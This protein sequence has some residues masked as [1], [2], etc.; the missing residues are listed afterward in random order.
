MASLKWKLAQKLEYIWWS[1]YLNKKAKGPYLQ[2]K[3]LYWKDL[4]LTISQD[5]PLPSNQAI[6]DAGCG[7]AGIFMVLDG[8]RVEAIDPLLDQ[9]RNLEH[10]QPKAYSWTTFYSAPIESLDAE[11]KYDI[12]FCINAINHVNDIELCCKNLVRA[13]KPDGKLILSTDAH[14]HKWLKKLF[15]ILPGDL[16]HPVQ[17]DIIEYE[18]L[19]TRQDLAIQKRVL[20]K[21]ENIFNYYILIANKPP[22]QKNA[23]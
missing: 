13:L 5:V 21:S 2:W 22:V 10:F 1:N 15:Q 17:K 14:R 9:Y 4:L 6:L 23:Y 16:L 7:P 18:H 20:Y 19:L 3:S 12:I 11:E 8:N